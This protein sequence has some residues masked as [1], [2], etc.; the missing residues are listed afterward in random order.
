M[1]NLGSV[2]GPAARS[3]LATA[4]R[5]PTEIYDTDFF[6]T[7][8]VS[9]L[10]S[11]QQIVPL[12]VALVR[13]QKV[14][15]LGCGTGAWLSVFKENGVKRVCGVDG[16][17]V[18]GKRLLIPEC[19]FIAADLGGPLPVTEPFD[20]AVSVEVAEHLVPKSGDRLVDSL[21]SL[22]PVV[23]FSAAI[24]YQGGVHH[25]NEQ[26]PT[27][28]IERFR[29]RGFVALDCLRPKLWENKWV[30]R[31]YAQ[32]LFLFVRKEHIDA[33]PALRSAYRALGA[34]PRNLVHPELWH[35]VNYRCG[36]AEARV[37]ELEDYCRH[38]LGLTPGYVSLKRTLLALPSLIIHAIKGRVVKR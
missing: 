28:W 26:W 36:C 10:C 21:T 22:A 30:A 16:R 17:W 25:T 33:V 31:Y 8:E 19:D 15:D 29:A 35:E 2:A 3:S 27:C 6:E 4:A 24:P 34:T 11:A 1:Q 38:L 9:A 14:V 13:P 32:N 18:V 7:I 23:L 37:A 5:D 20:L 12:V